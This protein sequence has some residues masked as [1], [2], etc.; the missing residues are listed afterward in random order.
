MPLHSCNH[1]PGSCSFVSDSY[2]FNLPRCLIQQ[3]H[4]FTLWPA[5]VQCTYWFLYFNKK[6]FFFYSWM[7]PVIFSSISYRFLKDRIVTLSGFGSSRS[8]GSWGLNNGRESIRRRQ[9]LRDPE[10]F[11]W[12]S[13]RREKQRLVFPGSSCDLLI[14]PV[15]S[16][17]AAVWGKTNTTLWLSHALCLRE[18]ERQ[19]DREDTKTFKL[20]LFITITKLQ[21]RFLSVL[22]YCPLSPLIESVLLQGLRSLRNVAWRLLAAAG[23]SLWCSISSP[24]RSALLNFNSLAREGKSQKKWEGK[25]CYFS[26]M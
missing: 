13:V 24:P 5:H 19:R 21:L 2:A 23:I 9:S 14:R 15:T 10:P 20:N 7:F 3:R 16:M 1:H 8:N 11:L 12:P 18:R 25:R 4:M 26:N 17:V 6:G 22:L